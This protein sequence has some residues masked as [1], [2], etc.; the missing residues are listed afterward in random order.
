MTV[1][2]VTSIT[3]K[4]A[5]YCRQSSFDG[6]GSSRVAGGALSAAVRRTLMLLW[7][8][9]VVPELRIGL[10]LH[11]ATS[12]LTVNLQRAF[13]S[14][15]ARPSAWLLPSIRS[16]AHDTTRTGNCFPA[17]AAC[18][19]LIP[20]FVVNDGC[21][22]GSASSRPEPWAR[23]NCC[24]SRPSNSCRACSTTTGHCGTGNAIGRLGSAAHS[25]GVG[26]HRCRHG[27]GSIASRSIRAR[28]NERL[29]P[30]LDVG[31]GAALIDRLF[32][33]DGVT[34]GVALGNSG[35]RP[36]RPT[37]KRQRRSFRKV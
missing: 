10:P 19:A 17:R 9:W 32:W 5:F 34:R 1:T 37:N 18:D 15:R 12:P 20:A 25:L 35:P 11:Y 2:V 28:R 23:S 26:W 3:D 14:S 27:A 13:S 21:R 8:W 29:L 24:R 7:G 31:I 6:L 30:K 4:T 22:F 36:V 16:P 33:V